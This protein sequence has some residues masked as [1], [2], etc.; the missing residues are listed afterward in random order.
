M[1]W[2]LAEYVGAF[3]LLSGVAREEE[4][5]KKKKIYESGP[6][7]G[8]T[9]GLSDVKSQWARRVRFRGRVYRDAEYAL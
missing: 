5:K 4:E 1:Y 2:S 9:Q 8:S 3:A 7:G 6:K